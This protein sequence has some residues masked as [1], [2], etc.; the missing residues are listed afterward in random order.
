MA[1]E[2]DANSVNN[3]SQTEERI[4]SVSGQISA[5]P[6]HPLIG[7]V[8]EILCLLGFNTSRLV[9]KSANSLA[10]LFIC[11]TLSE[12]LTLRDQWRTGQLKEILQKLFTLLSD[13]SEVV[14]IKALSW[15]E[16]DYEQSQS[17]FHSL[18]G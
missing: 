4:V 8:N 13:S 5:D 18:Q 17:N 15:S 16:E 6:Q 3:V 2:L 14:N 10:V 9:I 11:L 7:K 12:V 1:A